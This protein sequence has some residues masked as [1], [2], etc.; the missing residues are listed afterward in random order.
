MS[1][2]RRSLNWG[3][4]G[5]VAAA[6]LFGLLQ[7]AWTPVANGASEDM[8]PGTCSSEGGLCCVEVCHCSIT[9]GNPDSC[10][11]RCNTSC[12]DTGMYC[13]C[14]RDGDCEGLVSSAASCAFENH[15]GQEY[16]VSTSVDINICSELAS[17]TG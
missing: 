12:A 11:R 5:I 16:C 1:S 8:D 7:G 6:A 9:H 3:V 2:V 10:D 4:L 14:G 17:E 15:N 13:S